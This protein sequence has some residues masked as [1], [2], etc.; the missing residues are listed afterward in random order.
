[1][2]FPCSDSDYY[3]DQPVVVHVYFGLV[4]VLLISILTPRLLVVC[5]LDGVSTMLGLLQ[6]LVHHYLMMIMVVFDSYD[7]CYHQNKH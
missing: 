7:Y 1:M 2:M 5:M 4:Q 3:S 6:V